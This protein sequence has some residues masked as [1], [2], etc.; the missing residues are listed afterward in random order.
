MLSYLRRNA[1]S[2]MIKV[3]LIGIA[4]SFIIGFGILP[5][6]RD[7][8]GDS[9]VVAQVGDQ[10][11]TRGHWNQ[12]YENM[13]RFYKELY[14]DRFSDE[15]VK[16]MR[17]RETALDNLI[18]QALQ[19]QEAER[20]KLHVSDV[21]LQEKIRGLPYFQRDGAF[22]KELYLNLLRRNR[23]NPSEFEASQREELLIQKLQDLI[24]GGVK[25][26]D[27]EL[28]EQ[29]GLENEKVELSALVMDPRNFEEAV[30]VE[31]EALRPYFQKHSERFLWPEK[32]KVEYVKIPLAAYLDE[33]KV[34]TGEIE[35]YYDAHIDE[36]SYPEEVRLRH[37]LLRTEPGE[38][39]ASVAEKRER[40][41]GFKEKI[42]SGEDFSELAKAHSDDT[43]ARAGGDLGYVKRGQL[44]PEVE[45]AAFSLKPGDI[46]DIV[47]SSHGLHLVKVEEYRA[48]RVDPLEEVQEKIRE[49]LREEG[50]RRLARRRAEDVVWTAREG[51]GFSGLSSE[52]KEPL[53][54]EETGFFARGEALPDLGRETAFQNEAFQLEPGK[55]SD[56]VKGRDGYYVLRLL[57]RKA[58][59]VPPFEEVKDR[60]ETQYRREKSRDLAREKAEQVL[61]MA[62]DGK[63]FEEIAR[64][65]TVTSLETDPF[66][67]MRSYV[68][69]VGAS[70]E[71]V[72]TAFSL[73]EENPLSSK[74]FEVSGKYY[75]IRFNRFT[76]PDWQAYQDEKE[77]YRSTQLQRKSDEVF[78]QWLSEL[79][80]QRNVKVAPLS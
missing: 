1:G 19:K 50:A 29:Y 45:E 12:A 53:A 63:S 8:G 25:V 64:E 30:V 73:T 5:T 44:G 22:S 59:E 69:R 78:R 26:S 39:E 77:S 33:V 57:E 68:P 37:I 74:P 49:T 4:L 61:Q 27:E 17:L 14:K 58:P 35:E 28:R 24:R 51:N 16:Q 36:F 18:N 79:R 38:E 32:V 34:Y 56:A 66:S 55:T 2:W 76:K 71:L 15:M 72:E 42:A 31:D 46:S 52:G 11:I 3:I 48:S 65:E 40:L 7:P 43:S 70:P 23:M 47:V 75:V 67:R 60:V 41:R 9:N 54:V 6:L 80:E 62:Q 21:E 13:I 20:L 10:A